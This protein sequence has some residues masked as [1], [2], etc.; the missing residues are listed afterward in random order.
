[1]PLL[2]KCCPC[3]SHSDAASADEADTVRSP[4]PSHFASES[5]ARGAPA[6]DVDQDDTRLSPLESLRNTGA[7]GAKNATSAD[8][9]RFQANPVEFMQ[10]NVVIVAALPRDESDDS[11]PVPFCLYEWPAKTST[12]GKV[13]RLAPV[14][15]RVEEESQ[16][17]RAYLCDYRQ[18][19]CPSIRVGRDANLLLTP[20][21]SGCSIGVKP[22]H[23]GSLAFCHANARTAPNQIEKQVT[24]IHAC[25]GQDAIVINPNDYRYRYG[26][27][28]TVVGV[29][30]NDGWN[31]H[32]ASIGV[33][34]SF[35]H[36]G[37]TRGIQIPVP[38]VGRYS[39]RSEA[40]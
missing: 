4:D 8:I 22:G 21:L 24:D 11:R 35:N 40:S 38:V 36:S 34:P 12:I 1:M 5:Q 23:D 37:F 2:L 17:L 19:A 30:H 33:G 27:M 7:I 39:G 18:D 10:T 32:F 16:K 26:D 31:L 29:F 14:Q 20:T 3:A 15:N 25:L 28:A 13:Y 6:R 9:L